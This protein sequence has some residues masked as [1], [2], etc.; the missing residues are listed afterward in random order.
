MPKFL[1]N[2]IKVNDEEIT[3]SHPH[4]LKKH[5]PGGTKPGCLD[6]NDY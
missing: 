4:P 6:Y 1:Y 5:V 2:D 3:S